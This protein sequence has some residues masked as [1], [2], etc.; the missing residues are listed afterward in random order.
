VK[1]LD[2]LLYYDKLDSGVFHFN[3]APLSPLEL[4][5]QTF[6]MFRPQARGKDI[7]FK[8]VNGVDMDASGHG[9]GS[10]S[11]HPWPFC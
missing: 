9:H 1:L 11:G 4:V 6:E 7:R 10:G 8:L 5:G 3:D 2:E